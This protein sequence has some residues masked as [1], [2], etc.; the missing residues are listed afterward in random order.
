M[1]RLEMEGGLG[2]PS[3][4]T[5][6][7]SEGVIDARRR[8]RALGRGDGEREDEVG[9]AEVEL[10]TTDGLLE[11]IERRAPF[12]AVL[13]LVRLLDDRGMSTSRVHW[14]PHQRK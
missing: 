1:L 10:I 5:E 11:A 2:G 7:S 12:L 4:S 13:S 6:A 3:C 14:F 9:G 8:W